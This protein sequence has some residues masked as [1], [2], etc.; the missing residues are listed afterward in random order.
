MRAPILSRLLIG[1]VLVLA[2][3]AFTNTG[4]S[5]AASTRQSD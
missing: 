1:A 2:C 3:V 5:T 4:R